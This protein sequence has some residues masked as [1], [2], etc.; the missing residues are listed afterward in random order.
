MEHG[1]ALVSDKTAPSLFENIDTAPLPA[2]RPGQLAVATA[3]PRGFVVVL[4]GPQS[5][6][7][8]P[9]R[10]N[11][12]V[13][14]SPE[15]AMFIDDVGVSRQHASIELDDDQHFI[16]ND[17]GSRNGTRLNGEPVTRHR[18]ANGDRI[19]IGG[20][21]L[22]KFVIQDPLEIQVQEAQRLEAL[23]RLAG[24]LAHEFNNLLTVVI[25]NLEHLRVTAGDNASLLEC[26]DDSLFEAR[27]GAQLTRNLLAFA[28]R[29]PYD[30]KPVDV[31]GIIEAFV[32]L[33]ERMLPPTIRLTTQRG[34][35]LTTIGD[36]AQLHQ[37]LLNLG[38]N[39]RDAMP[40]G[41]ALTITAER[42]TVRAGDEDSKL[43]V[44]P[45]DHV[46]VRVKDGGIGMD[47]QTRDQAFEPFFTTHE[48][49]TGLG[50]AVVDSIVR[51]HNG[52]IHLETAPGAGATFTVYLPAVGGDAARTPAQPTSTAAVADGVILVIDD[53][54]AVR[55]SIK[56]LL[57]AAGFTVETSPSGA[58]AIELV[59]RAPASVGVALVDLAMPGLDGVAT[60]R[61]LRALAPSLPVILMSGR[62]DDPRLHHVEQ[63]NDVSLLLKPF[64]RSGLLDAITKAARR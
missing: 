36:S 40:D 16:L 44:E 48:G 50:L 56:R 61:Q 5:G 62:L 54:E 8:I 11:T 39:A 49:S 35:R 41:G 43:G 27:R 57:V 52:L 23:G 51:G 1:G 22:L 17:L 13:G 29:G 30:P 20:T 28:R 32:R 3:R 24:N 31:G 33:F 45:G 2:P 4:R 21:A 55:R 6:R 18:L 19:E 53:D 14:R 60:L 15:A 7:M 38:L 26:L 12:I 63:D 10:G 59:Q 34:E 37:V 25:N 64:E 58:A 47:R 46:V 42:V 9:I